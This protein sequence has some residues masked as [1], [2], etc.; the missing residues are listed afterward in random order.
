MDFILTYIQIK[1]LYDPQDLLSSYQSNKLKLQPQDVANIVH[2]LSFSILEFYQAFSR[3][4]DV[5]ALRL[6]HYIFGY[7][8]NLIRYFIEPEK[9]KIPVKGFKKITNYEN[10]KK[11]QDICKALTYS[12]SLLAVQMIVI[13]VDN[14][15]MQLPI[16]VAEYLN[17]DFFLYCKNLIFKIKGV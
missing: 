9:S 5:W 17:I 3:K 14:L 16:K 12:T 1:V 13:E 8:T 15:V 4:D 7:Y 10:Y 11:Y 2:E 6:A